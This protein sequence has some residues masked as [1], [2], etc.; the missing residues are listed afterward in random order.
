MSYRTQSNR[1]WMTVIAGSLVVAVA[2]LV[3]TV[4]NG[5][6][7]TRSSVIRSEPLVAFSTVAVS[8]ADIRDRNIEFYAARAATDPAS[9]N[10][11]LALA[12]L[13]FSRSRTNGSVTDLAR[14]ELL[15]RESVA[16]RR[17]R[18]GQAFELLAS[19]LMARHAFA[20]ARAV[21]SRADSLEPATPSHLALLG[22]IELELG[23]YDAAATHF[24]AIYYDRQQFT[25]GSR[26]ARWYEVTGRADMARLFLKNA[27]KH[28]DER[29]D[30]PREQV[31]WFHYRLGELELRLGNFAAAD[32]ALQDGLRRN[33]DDVRVLGALSRVALAQSDWSRAIEYGDR[34]TGVQLDPTTLGA[35]S[36]AYAA[37][38]D[39][40]QAAYYAR[41]MSVSALKQPG[42]IHRAWGLFLLDHGTSSEREQVLA[43][44]TRELRDRQDVYGHD[45]V[46]WA[47]YRTGHDDEARREMRL[48]LAQHTQDEMLITHAA[49]LGVAVL[50]R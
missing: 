19:V 21:A 18:N 12:G 24:G 41:A 27:I 50:P 23:E 15:A 48:A 6:L 43:R 44:A 36:R 26:L 8:D 5:R 1:P 13:L 38:G 32:S 22:E 2:V 9:S 14:A 42:V 37:Q 47:L 35:V 49:A 34:A 17:Q 3:V 29:D 11:R 4:A 46:A 40:T 39:T 16:L 33:P 30:L 31:A 10:D 25:I 20:E 45:L 28:V 7:A